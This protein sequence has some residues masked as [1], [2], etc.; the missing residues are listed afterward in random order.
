MVITHS[1]GSTHESWVNWIPTRGTAKKS[2]DSDGL[3]LLFCG[4]WHT[5]RYTR[6]SEWGVTAPVPGAKEQA[7][8]MRC[9]RPRSD[10]A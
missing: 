2:P 10:R 5:R 1:K 6:K 9:S 8:A 4:A 7:L 3:R